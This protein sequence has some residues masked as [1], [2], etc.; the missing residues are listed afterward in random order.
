[1]QL[2]VDVRDIDPVR[3]DD[4]LNTIRRACEETAAKRNL[5]VACAVVNQDLPAQSD[6]TAI[7][8]I[9]N[10]CKELG[11][12][13]LSMISRAYHDSLFLSRVGPVAMIFIPCRGGVSHRPD[14]FASTA[15]IARGAH[16]LAGALARLAG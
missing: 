14:E 5:Q 7:K 6:A 13:S 11:V 2:L 15:D 9:Q 4:V 10:T 16:V 3:R 8:A 12:T 1:V